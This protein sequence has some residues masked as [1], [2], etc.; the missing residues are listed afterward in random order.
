MKIEFKKIST[1]DLK[2]IFPVISEQD[3]KLLAGNS[4]IILD[5]DYERIQ[6][7]GAFKVG[8]YDISK[9]LIQIAKGESYDPV[10]S[11]L[12]EKIQEK[13]V[14]A[15]KFVDIMFKGISLEKNILLYGKGGH[16]SCLVI[17]K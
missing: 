13:Y 8:P 11:A 16:G 9:D 1:V 6:K 14:Y 2:K 15:D 12:L 5:K 10:Q 3:Y 17:R 4:L 7:S